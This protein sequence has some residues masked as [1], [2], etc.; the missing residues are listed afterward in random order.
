MGGPSST[1][2]RGADT[3]GWLKAQ[4]AAQG[5]RWTLWTPV[6]FGLGAAG[7]MTLKVEPGLWLFI[8]LALATAGLAVAARRYSAP[9]AVGVATVLLAF[10][11]AGG[12]A[13]KLRSDRV[14]APIAPATTAPRII[15]GWVVDVASPGAGGMRLLIAPVWISG[16]PPEDTPVRVRVTLRDGE[17]PPPG[18]AISL[19]AVIGPPPSPASP[20][21]YDFAR[22]AWFRRV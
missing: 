12:L 21:A 8:G 5:H 2:T 15:D 18:S 10:A 4:A 16:L 19:R 3:L 20:G 13:G 14:A 11:A 9:G 6:A 1:S 17:I 22:D 7:Y